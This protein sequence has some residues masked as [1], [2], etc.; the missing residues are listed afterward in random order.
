MRDNR[1]KAS[2]PVY[3]FTSL[4]ALTIAG[5]LFKVVFV[6]YSAAQLSAVP[7]FD[8]VYALFWGLRFDLASAALLSLLSC[9]VLWFFY[10][11]LP[12][13]DPAL[14]LLGSMLL[15]QMSLQIGD[16]VYFA[17]AGRHV[18][19]EMRDV[20]ID[21]SGLFM[22]AISKHGGFIALSY[23]LALMIMFVLLK[24]A[25]KILQLA[26]GISLLPEFKLKHE[27]ALLSVV[28]LAVILVRG[29]VSG[30]PQSVISAFKIGDAQQ[31]VISMNGAYSVVYG[32]INSHKE[33]TR[34]EV[35]LP[36]DVDV[37]YI[38]TS[39]YPELP[40]FSAPA[41]DV[42][43]YNL[44]FIL[45]EG[46]PA[47]RMSAYGYEK[48]TTPFYAS[49]KEKSIAPLGV[50][51]GGVRTTEGIYAIFCSQQNPLGKT[52]AQTSLQNNAYSCLPYILKQWGWHTAFFQGSHKETSGTGAFAQSLGFSE[53]YAKEDMPAGRFE[54]NYWGAHDPDIYDFV[55]DKLDAMPQPFMVGINTNSTH[56][57]RVPEGV[58]PFFGDENSEQKHQSILRFAD[59]AM[60]EFFQ[61]IKDKPYYNNTVFVLLSDHTGG[62][63]KTTAARYFIPGI[64]YAENLVPKAEVSCYVSQRDFSPSVLDLLGLPASPSFAGE[65]F[66][67]KPESL[68]SY[69]RHFADYF[70]AGTIGWL[71]ENRLVETS[72]ANP[73]EMKCYSIADGLLHAQSLS[74][75]EQHKAQSIKSLVFTSHSQ[76][77]LFS[78]E[79]QKFYSFYE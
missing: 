74:C 50:I 60:Q 72:V 79:T 9:F 76:H 3:F 37:Q 68:P 4:L 26:S 53:S 42:K 5:L 46:W 22:T 65:S 75:D 15:L 28:L 78:G 19:Y 52:V 67:P 11:L 38:M 45:M 8:I 6:L 49:L 14:F 51:S 17:E 39:L 31:A 59:S 77:L 57:I 10:R 44:V 20:L 25:K 32:A 40:D 1:N 24:L 12:A 7:S 56:D 64:I 23:V 70:D 2:L 66:L 71:S 54:H 33:I 48:P 69:D 30:L 29:G 55:L 61:K 58:E 63:H 62:T 27:A 21:A 41:N 16:A 43:K 18:S 34:V 13:K 35:N 73:S 36:A 47:D